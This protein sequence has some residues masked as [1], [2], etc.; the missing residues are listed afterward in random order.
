MYICI[1]RRNASAI[2]LKLIVWGEN[3]H[4]LFFLLLIIKKF[5]HPLR[6]RSHEVHMVCYLEGFDM[7]NLIA[8]NYSTH[9]F[10]IFLC[11]L[12]TFP[13]GQN[14]LNIIK[15][16]N[17]NSFTYSNIEITLQKHSKISYKVSIATLQSL[18]IWISLLLKLWMTNMTFWITKSLDVV[19]N[20]LL[21]SSY[22]SR[23]TLYLN[24]SSPKIMN[25]E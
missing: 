22:Y 15:W 25:D 23:I 12:I 2:C 8:H 11:I 13:K 16:K 21:A 20:E 5:I 3:T 24:F 7:D 6:K 9:L 14:K 17:N 1:K 19:T 10:C 4:T 18:F